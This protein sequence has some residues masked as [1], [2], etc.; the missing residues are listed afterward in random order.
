ML[1]KQKKSRKLNVEAEN[2]AKTKQN[3]RKQNKSGDGEYVAYY[4][5][6]P[7]SMEPCIYTAIWV[8][9]NTSRSKRD[10]KTKQGHF[11]SFTTTPAMAATAILLVIQPI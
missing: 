8:I 5:V 11:T 1:T 2:C 4:N 6:W 3:K 10:L 9:L 7:G